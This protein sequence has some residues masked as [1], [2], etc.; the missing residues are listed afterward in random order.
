MN[1]FKSLGQSPIKV[2]ELAIINAL[3]GKKFEKI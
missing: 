3:V 1:F 2:N